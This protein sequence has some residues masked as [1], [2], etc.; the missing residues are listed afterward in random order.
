[1]NWEFMVTAIIGSA[2]IG[3]HF[4]SLILA[5]G[6]YFCLLAINKSQ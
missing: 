4:G 6:I 1:M 5:I 2:L 3:A